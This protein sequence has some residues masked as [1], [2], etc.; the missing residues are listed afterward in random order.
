MNDRETLKQ[1]D[2]FFSFCHRLGD[3]EIYGLDVRD[4]IPVIPEPARVARRYP[5]R[6]QPTVNHSRRERSRLRK[7]MIDTCRALENGTLPK[8]LVN[9]GM[10]VEIW[11]EGMA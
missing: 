10:P 5:L 2:P 6:D 7:A 4:R 1:Y 9:G 11:L 8:V 3:A